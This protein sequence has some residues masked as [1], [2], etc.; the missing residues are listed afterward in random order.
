MCL[1]A[2]PAAG[3]TSASTPVTS[4]FGSV[5]NYQPISGS[6]RF[7]WFLRS[8]LGPE[9]LV[10]GAVTAGFGTAIDKPSEYGP[11][12]DGFGKR[13]GI[14][15]TGVATSNAIESSLGS[16]WG[17]DPRYFRDPDQPFKTRL[18]HV[19]LTTFTAPGADGRYRPAYARLVAIPGNNFLSNTWRAD[20]ES[21][22]RDAALRTLYGFLGRMGSNA[23]AEFWP[24]V[25][26]RAFHRH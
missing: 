1:L 15:L 10:A 20:S 4:R 8:T 5:Q 17:E 18:G 21:D 12:W 13:Y 22:N 6:E 14:R 25:K 3:Q 7:R 23:F 16:L 9:S 11:H 26:Q 24:D 2:L 19:V